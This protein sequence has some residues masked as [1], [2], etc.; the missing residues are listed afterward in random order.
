MMTVKQHIVFFVQKSLMTNVTLFT[1][2]DMSM[3]LNLTE[4]IFIK[5]IFQLHHTRAIPYFL[6]STLPYWKM[7]VLVCRT[8]GSVETAITC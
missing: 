5:T 3:I 1:L 2:I 4:L 8:L 7:M 6:P